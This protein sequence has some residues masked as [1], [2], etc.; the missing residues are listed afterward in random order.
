MSYEHLQIEHVHIYIY[1][2]EHVKNTIFSFRECCCI[3]C[4]QSSYYHQ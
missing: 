2:H 1:R 3:C 4:D